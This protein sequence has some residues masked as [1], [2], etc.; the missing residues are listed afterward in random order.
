MSR[1]C[2]MCGN[3]MTG[4][5]YRNSLDVGTDHIC[6]ACKKFVDV[7]DDSVPKIQKLARMGEAT[8][9]M[10]DGFL[11]LYLTKRMKLIIDSIP[12][13]E[14]KQAL[15]LQSTA[16]KKEI[17]LKRAES[18]SQFEDKLNSGIVLVTT[19]FIPGH[20]IKHMLGPVSGCVAFGAGV[21][22]T[23]AASLSATFG[24]KSSSFSKQIAHTRREAEMAMLEEARSLC[25]NAVIDVHYTVSNFAAD[26]TGVL[27]TGTAVVIE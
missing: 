14:K 11:K 23:Y 5:E 6:P 4:D 24:T 22:K 25:A 20:N 13:E 18:A 12:E 1:I 9:F 8:Q 17:D 16:Q 7:Y 19:D 3:E 2:A 15:E 10:K 26:L 27:V 21:L